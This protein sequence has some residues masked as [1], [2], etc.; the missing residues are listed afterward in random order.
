[1]ATIAMNPLSSVHSEN[2]SAAT[3]PPPTV[4][5]HTDLDGT[6]PNPDAEAGG[7]PTSFAEMFNRDEKDYMEQIRKEV[8]MS[9]EEKFV[10][11]QHLRRMRRMAEISESG[12]VQEDYEHYMA[13]FN[14]TEE[15][16]ESAEVPKRALELEFEDVHCEWCGTC[17][18]WF[19]ADSE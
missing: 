3:T 8:P 4:G 9:K 10:L 17:A 19:R 2:Q 5:D 16:M 18:I 6:P 14:E 15:A 12:V 1:M 7:G 13:I 11:G